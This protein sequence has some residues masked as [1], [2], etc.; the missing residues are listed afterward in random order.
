MNKFKRFFQK[1][2][3]KFIVLAICATFGGWSGA[4]SLSGILAMVLYIISL[5][6][7]MQLS[8]EWRDFEKPKE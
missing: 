3:V 8:F 6:L 1:N 4:S 5:A 2:K 7:A